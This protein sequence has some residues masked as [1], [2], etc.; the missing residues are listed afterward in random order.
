MP[1]AFLFLR[2]L[3]SRHPRRTLLLLGPGPESIDK[4]AEVRG[5]LSS[6]CPGVWGA[7][8]HRPNDKGR[9]EARVSLLLSGG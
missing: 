3:E 2:L 5:R 1:S 4:K 8:H 9:G 6:L 7:T